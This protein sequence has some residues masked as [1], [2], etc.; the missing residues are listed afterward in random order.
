M[1]NSRLRGK[2]KIDR[3][4]VIMFKDRMWRKT[5]SR[6]ANGHTHGCVGVDANRNFDF[7]WL[8]KLTVLFSAVAVLGWGR[9]GTGP[10]NLAQAPPKFLIGSN[11]GI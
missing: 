1:L 3:F 11:W 4:L 8:C 2:E 5:R 7:Q 10:P 6:V 9:G